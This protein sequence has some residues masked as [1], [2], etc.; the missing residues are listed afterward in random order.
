MFNSTVTRASRRHRGKHLEGA[1][2]DG[3]L[4]P[5]FT[6]L[7]YAGSTPLHEISLASRNAADAASPPITTVCEALRSG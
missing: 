4:T 7:I 3:A 2:Q 5:D 1:V 6:N